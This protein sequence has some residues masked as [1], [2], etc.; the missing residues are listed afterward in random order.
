MSR[1]AVSGLS[2]TWYCLCYLCKGHN[3]V[4]IVI[5]SVIFCAGF[6]KKVML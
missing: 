5:H 4:I 1:C 2:D 6:L 3:V